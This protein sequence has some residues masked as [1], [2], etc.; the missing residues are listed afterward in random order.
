MAF[1]PIPKTSAFRMVLPHHDVALFVQVS[2]GWV[3]EEQV[4]NTR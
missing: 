4:E 2:L 1:V 3:Q